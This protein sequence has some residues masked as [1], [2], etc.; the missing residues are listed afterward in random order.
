MPVIHLNSS[1]A[2][3][4]LFNDFLC[5]RGYLAARSDRFNL[6]SSVATKRFQQAQL[7][8]LG[9]KSTGVIAVDGTPGNHSL[10]LACALGFKQA[11]H[12]QAIARALGVSYPK[13]DPKLPR[14]LSKAEMEALWGRL[15][16]VAAPVDGDETIA[17]TNG[18]DTNNI[19]SIQ[20][21]QLARIAGDE[22]SRSL[23]IHRK[24]AEQFVQLWAAWE[25]QGLLS[26]LREFGGTYAPRFVRG[27]TKVLSNHAYG[28]AFDINTS[29]NWLGHLPAFPGENGNLFQHVE[30]AQA[31]GFGWG[32][33]YEG[34]LDGMHFEAMRVLGPAELQATAARF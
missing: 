31:F 8:K 23:K 13:R 16:Y 2:L 28:T 32:G 26:R 14:T 5:M 25:R 29:S 17:I 4:R 15:E 21:P 34:R 10:G 9:H 7:D 27:S 6:A 22:K 12:P 18:W 3:P 30:A 20:V 11:L 19:V 24:V 33:F 1:G